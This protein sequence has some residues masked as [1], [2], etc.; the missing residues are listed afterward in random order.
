MKRIVAISDIQSPFEDRKAVA[1]VARFIEEYKPDDVISVGDEADF[2]QISRY[3]RGGW[4]EWEGDLGKER[5][6]TVEILQQLQIKHITRSNHLDRWFSALDRVP[7]FHKVPEFQLKNF[8]RFEQLG[9][10][11]HEKPWDPTGTGGWLLM[12]GDEAGLRS[13]AGATALQLS[14]RTGRSIVCGHTHRG[15]LIPFS[16]SFGGQMRSTTWGLECGNLM[17]VKHA[18]YMKV[19]NWQ[20]GFG[21]LT[22]TGKTVHPQFVPIQNRSFVV[23]GTQY[24]W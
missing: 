14:V 9:I 1:A 2:K 5:D 20:Q 12:H 16:T 10:T 21:L 19:H 18:R 6:H 3:D 13:G 24:R 8:L 11:Y 4:G 23:D 7:A 17:D 15:G 22:V